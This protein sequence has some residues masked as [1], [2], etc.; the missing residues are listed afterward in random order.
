MGNLRSRIRGL[1]PDILRSVKRNKAIVEARRAHHERINAEHP[2]PAELPEPA[3]GPLTAAMERNIAKRTRHLKRSP[4]G[5]LLPMARRD[6]EANY[7]RQNG[8]RRLTAAQA[9]RAR[10]KARTRRKALARDRKRG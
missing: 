7:W 5:V 9:R 6:R 1:R 2:E 10:K 4:H 8:V 3:G